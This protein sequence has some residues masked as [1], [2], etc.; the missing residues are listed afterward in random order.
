MIANIEKETKIE[1]TK[2]DLVLVQKCCP[3][4]QLMIDTGCRTIN[5]TTIELEESVFEN[6]HFNIVIGIPRCGSTQHWTI[7]HYPQSLDRL[8]LLNNG[9]LR[10]TIFQEDFTQEVEEKE[11]HYSIDM[12]ES[13][14]KDNH[15]IPSLKGKTKIN[16][17]YSP[18]KYCLDQIIIHDHQTE[19]K[20]A[21]ICVPEPVSDATRTHFLLMH[22]VNP[23]LHGIAIILY[24]LVAV[25]YFVVPQLRD[26]VGNI[27]TTIMICLIVSQAASLVRIFTQFSNHVSFMIAGIYLFIFYY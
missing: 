26:L 4:G 9:F 18:G 16:Y 12:K 5:E 6:K 15:D 19:G 20:F 3:E 27:N 11:V 13:D 23:I 25:I 21:I 14:I 17:D 8:E 24:L 7:L 22:I 2:P 1:P 10:H